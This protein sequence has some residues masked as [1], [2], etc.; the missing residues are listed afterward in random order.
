MSEKQQDHSPVSPAAIAPSRSTPA[1]DAVTSFD[2]SNSSLML[3]LGGAALRATARTLRTLLTTAT[4]EA[5]PFLRTLTSFRNTVCPLT[6]LIGMSLRSALV[7]GI[8]LVR[9]VYCVSPILTSPD[10]KL[11]GN[12]V[13]LGVGTIVLAA[14]IT[15]DVELG[16][17]T[18]GVEVGDDCVIGAGAAVIHSIPAVVTAAGVPSRV[19]GPRE[20]APRA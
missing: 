14:M 19:L 1:I 2:W 7:T 15:T 9:T 6:Y 10:A 16:A 5:L 11:I 8:A 12:R 17:Y 3:R 13:G 4:V 20:R 18:P